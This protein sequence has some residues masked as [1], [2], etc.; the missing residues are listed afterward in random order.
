[1]KS[2]LHHFA[3]EFSI[4][5]EKR[6]FED[7]QQRSIHNPVIF[8]F[9]GDKVTDSL[10][11][12]LKINEE[13]WNNSLGVQYVH[14]FQEKS[15]SHPNVLSFQLPVK[16]ND[17]KQERKGLYEAFYESEE[18]LIEMNRLFRKLSS[19]ISEYGK[20]YSSLQKVN[21]CV[22]TRVDDPT[23]VLIQEFTLLLKNI[24]L[25]SFKAIE[26]DLYGLLKEKHQEETFAYSASL[27]MSFLKELD[28]YQGSDYSFQSEIQV[29]EDGFRLPVSQTNMPLFDLVY[30]LSDK[31]ENGLITNTADEGN[32]EII[33]SM[34]LLKNRKMLSDYNDKI[35]GYNNSLFQK[36]IRGSDANAYATAG[37]AKVK[38]PNKSIALYAV[39]HFYQEWLTWMES[40]SDQ[41]REKLLELLGLTET[42][43]QS[44]LNEVMPGRE[45]LEDMAGLMS[46]GISYQ[47]IKK[48]SVKQ[49]EEALY[50]RGM[51]QFFSANVNELAE[52][53]I[54][55]LPLASIMK[56]CIK[57]QIIQHDNYGF[58]CAYVWT[59]DSDASS[60][61]AIRETRRLILECKKRL[62]ETE[63]MLEQQYQQTV[64]SS[65]FHKVFLPFSDKKNLRHFQQYLFQT[66]YGTKYEMVRLQMKLEILK[67]Y[68][69]TLDEEHMQLRSKYDR[70][71]QIKSLLKQAV[72]EGIQEED[73][74]L[75]KNLSDYYHE[76]IVKI[77][78]R[79]KDKRGE[80]FF[81]SSRYFGNILS[82]LTS[83]GELLLERLLQVC[84]QD[85]LTEAEFHRSF[86]DELLDRS[87]VQVHYGNQEV[88]SK[89]DLFQE[90]YRRLA[91]NSVVNIEIYNFKQK[92]R[93]EEKYFF[94]DISSQFMQFAL[95]RET[96]SNRSKIGSVHEKKSSGIEKLS[97]MGGF[98]LEDLMYYRNGEKYYQLY[99]E[100]GFLLHGQELQKINQT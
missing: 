81:N 89:E 83:N 58:I 97:I 95:D 2:I 51:E 48:L 4:Q 43:L 8:L 93:Y 87:N 35:D 99:L 100:N 52:D 80:N 31:N 19:N 3:E 27:G 64:E 78:N 65:D 5:Q 1:M 12:M 56:E 73:D 66:V 47:G 42:S 20:L 61:N 63:A 60:F 74:Y 88:L 11:T 44:H 55:R 91:E 32:L 33:S 39:N 21:L 49:A 90:L 84:S 98:Q 10:P 53:A 34:N 14:V 22:V 37:F 54:H 41:P 70:V 50:D 13:K 68:E 28:F 59:K 79:L 24:L 82:L 92:H 30:L 15:Y 38:R 71:E 45:K 67:K 57:E 17:R 16:T 23:N 75:A 85:I 26:I 76:V 40:K 25:E 36:A 77:I 94:G 69:D 46:S 72:L 29:T 7:D 62:A 9:L 86:E 96:E 6:T 18:K